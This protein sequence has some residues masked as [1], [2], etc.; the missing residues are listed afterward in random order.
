MG[1]STLTTTVA[2]P[3]LWPG[4]PDGH[5]AGCSSRRAIGSHILMRSCHRH[6]ACDCRGSFRKRPS[7][8]QLL[9]ALRTWNSAASCQS[10][11]AS[12]TCLRSLERASAARSAVG[13]RRTCLLR[14][15][16]QTVLRC[17]L[18]KRLCS[19]A[20]SHLLPAQQDTL[21]CIHLGPKIHRKSRYSP[22]LSCRHRCQ[23][24]LCRSPQAAPS[25]YRRSSRIHSESRREIPEERSLSTWYTFA[26]CLV[27]QTL[28]RFRLRHEVIC[29]SSRGCNAQQSSNLSQSVSP[30]H[31]C[32]KAAAAIHC[33]S[34]LPNIA[35]GTLRMG[36]IGD[37]QSCK[38]LAGGA[39]RQSG[40]TIGK[41]TKAL[42]EE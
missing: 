32:R 28:T 24:S 14:M 16:S 8:C 12:D 27:T 18:C 29:G 30:Q 25:R 20:A 23:G 6:R 13:R 15:N 37:E 7:G 17:Y 4:T 2:A 22:L 9:H 19:H 3:L 39:D 34:L 11:R 31:V 33:L 10:S 41:G 36:C 26:G 1:K 5:V 35:Q 40:R 38:L 42:D 21:Q